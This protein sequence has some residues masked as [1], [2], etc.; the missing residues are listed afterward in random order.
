MRKFKQSSRAAAAAA[1]LALVLGA[2]LA[3]NAADMMDHFWS[4]KPTGTAWVTGYGEC[5]QSTQGPNDLEPCVK[6]V[7]AE[8]VVR[9]NFEFDKYRIENV[10]NDTELA[11]LDDYIADVNATQS[12]EQ[13]TLVGHTDAKGSEAYNDTLGLNRANAVRDYMVS[14]GIPASDIV[15]V[16]SRGERDMLPEFDVYSVKQRRVTIRS[17]VEG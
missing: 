7:P 14:K 13:L 10:V 2:P 1:S 17:E 12:R 6:P 8:F 5:W 3:A 16:E 9:L 15:S 11:R 4:A